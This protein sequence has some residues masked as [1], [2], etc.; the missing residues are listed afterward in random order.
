M[1]FTLTESDYRAR[2]ICTAD[3]T[4]KTQDLYDVYS[5]YRTILD[6][7][8]LKNIGFIARVS[9]GMTVWA[10]QFGES[11]RFWVLGNHIRP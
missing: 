5:K 1:I 6:Y 3:F 10:M 9:G 11:I 8:D 7:F 2:C 4:V